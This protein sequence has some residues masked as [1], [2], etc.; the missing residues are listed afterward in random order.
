GDAA[1]CTTGCAA[2]RQRRPRCPPPRTAGTGPM[3]RS[4]LSRDLFGRSPGR[5][6]PFLPGARASPHAEAIPVGRIA[7][8]IEFPVDKQYLFP[9]PRASRSTSC[10]LLF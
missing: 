7:L 5:S 3:L 8:S 2:L 6:E 4:V 9:A 10:V 1:P